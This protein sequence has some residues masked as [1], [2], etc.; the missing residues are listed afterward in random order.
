MLINTDIQITYLKLLHRLPTDQEI[1]DATD[2]LEVS[3]KNTDEYK[4]LHNLPI[5]DYSFDNTNNTFTISKFTNGYKQGCLLTNGSIGIE[6]SSSHNVASKAFI[7]SDHTEHAIPDFTNITLQL[8]NSNMVLSNHS[9]SLD[10]NN[11]KFIDNFTLNSD[12]DVSIEKF[13][14]HNHPSCFL[15]K[16]TVT[17]A[18]N[19]DLSFHHLFDRKDE[20]NSFMLS[21]THFSFVR[22]NTIMVTNMYGF[23]TN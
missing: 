15:Q 6:T 13:P 17:S 18:Q 22:D 4:T 10:M 1:A 9:Q 20:S 3:L 23:S 16:V 2:S 12:I 21:S 5:F 19:Y 8:N 14:L 11:C 7:K